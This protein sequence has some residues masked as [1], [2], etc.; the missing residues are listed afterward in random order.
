MEPERLFLRKKE[1][2]KRKTTSVS[3]NWNMKKLGATEYFSGQYDEEA[4]GQR[5]TKRME[6]IDWNTRHFK[7]TVDTFFK[8]DILDKMKLTLPIPENIANDELREYRIMGKKNKAM[9]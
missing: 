6:P 5:V 3:K 9:V 8:K 4:K 2:E 1:T 7:S